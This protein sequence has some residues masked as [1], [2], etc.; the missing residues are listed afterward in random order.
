[1]FDTL[2]ELASL[3]EELQKDSITLVRAYQV[4]NRTV[5]AVEK[6]KEKLS[7]HI[8]EAVEGVEKQCYRSV[9]VIQ[10]RVG[11]RKQAAIDRNQFLQSIADNMRS[12]LYTTI[13]SNVSTQN[14]LH[15][16]H[17]KSEYDDLVSQ[18]INYPVLLYQKSADIVTVMLV[19][20]VPR[21]FSDQA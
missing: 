2:E 10:H 16:N 9:P 8:Q 3:S 14:Q 17:N 1:M 7:V 15:S 6:M 11:S 4:I 20:F 13:A 21:C 19:S 5:R 18:V 12:R